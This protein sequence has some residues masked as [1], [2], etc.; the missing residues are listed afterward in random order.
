MSEHSRV[1]PSSAE[2]W[3][4]CH[5]SVVMQER[6]PQDEESE[7]SRAGTAAHWVGSSILEQARSGARPEAINYVN[8]TAPNGVVI[9]EEMTEAADL[10]AEEVLSVCNTPEKLASLQIEKKVTVHR[11]HKESWGTPD[12]W[13]YDSQSGILYVWDFKFGHRVVHPYENWQMINY[14][15]GLLD[16]LFAG[17]TQHD[18]TVDIRVV[19]PRSYHHEGPVR[20]W[21]PRS[22]MLRSY[23]NRLE[24][25]AVA[26]LG[27]D[28]ST[29]S[30]PWCRDCTGRHVC[31][32]FQESAM[33]AVDMI[34]DLSADVL[35][36]DALGLEITILE[37]AAKAVEYRLEGLKQQAIGTVRNGGMV[38]GW[39]TVQGLGRQA[40]NKPVAEVLALGDCMKIDLRKPDEP[41]TPKQAIKAG[42]DAAVI[43]AYSHTPLKGLK[44]VPD[45]GKA[46]RVFTKTEG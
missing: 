7:E 18:I 26:A 1:P 9:T 4:H 2:R 45:A 24:S 35:P 39:I 21:A 19:Q 8:Q 17:T 23:A 32:T 10:Y 14:S 40:W 11:V 15:I 33:C 30:G 42:I 36:P 37:R 28:P 20:T 41:M 44:L 38:P 12:A 34:G 3:V 16:L 13:W 5:G 43:S 31:R 46:K 27:D 29:A 22:V 6:Y 25:G